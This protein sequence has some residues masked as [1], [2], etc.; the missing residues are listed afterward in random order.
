MKRAPWQSV[1]LLCI[2]AAPACK[3]DI[4]SP[5]YE[6]VLP[7]T[8]AA[9]V[10]NP[11]FP[12]LPGTRLEY[13]GLTDE[14][15]ETIVIEVLATARIVNGVRAV[16]LRDRVYIDN[17]LVEDTEDWFAQ[18]AEGNVW[19]LG[20]DSKEIAN[21]Q[22][23][24]RAGSW[25]WGQNGALPGIIMWAVPSS[26]VGET[27]R[28]EYLRGEAEDWGRVVAVNQTVTVPYG[29]LTNCIETEDWNGLEP[30]ERERKF[31]CPNIGVTL[32]TA[33]SE[34]VEL[35]QLSRD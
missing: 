32:E 12:L 30:D 20:E 10:T 9:S 21:G 1:I 13:R 29:T 23:V 6:P 5:P 11:Y 8:W 7:T 22:V 31:Y 35:I 33:G 2:L 16:A 19:Y 28:Q 27:Y 15:L 34:R 18:D 14:G 4:F 3:D 25:Q 24:S 26:H 17:E